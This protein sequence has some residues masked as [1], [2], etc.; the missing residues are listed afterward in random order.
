MSKFDPRTTP[1]KDSIAADF[2]ENQ[3]DNNK[4]T[5]IKAQKFQTAFGITN[6]KTQPNISSPLVSQLLYGEKFDVYEIKEGWAWGQSAKDGYVG[7]CL[8]EEL[9]PDIFPTTHYL[10]ELSSFIYTDPNAKMPPLT[11]IHMMSELSL[12]DDRPHEGFMQ[13][14]DGNWIYAEHVSKDFGKCTVSEAMKFLYTPYLWGG[15]SNA[16]IDCSGLVQIAFAAT[17][18]DVPRDS[19]MQLK[20]LGRILN[21]DEIPQ[22]GDLAFFPSHV[23]FMLDDIHILHAN[24]HHMRVSINPLREVIDVVSFQTD[25]PALTCI[26]RLE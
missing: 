3:L 18:V 24:Q 12:I 14:I 25:A 11:H 1:F 6:L 9:S 17:G 2:L 20:T 22:K 13:L 10:S 7:Y 16:G 4:F 19:D 5:F 8:L 21:D 26:K 23:G 15:R